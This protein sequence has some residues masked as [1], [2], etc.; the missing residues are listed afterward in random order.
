MKCIEDKHSLFVHEME[1]F[2]VKEKSIGNILESLYNETCFLLLGLVL[3][4]VVLWA[5][6]VGSL[7]R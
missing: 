2:R 5:W 7:F 3:K 4:I 1:I 6:I